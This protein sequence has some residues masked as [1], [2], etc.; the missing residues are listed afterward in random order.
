MQ[1]RWLQAARETRRSQLAY[2]GKENPD[3]AKRL[4]DLIDAQIMRLGDYPSVGRAGRDPGTR[5]LVIPRTQFIAVY[6]ITPTHIAILRLL[7]G[8]QQWPPGLD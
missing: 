8:A 5:E 1:I 3:A 7:H 6:R 2:I 4:A